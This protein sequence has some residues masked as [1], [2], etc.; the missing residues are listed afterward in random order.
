MKKFYFTFFAAAMSLAPL[1]AQSTSEALEFENNGIWYTILDENTCQTRAG[2]FI[3]KDESS[4]SFTVNYGNDASNI[5]DLNIPAKVKNEEKEYTVVKIGEFGF[6]NVTNITIPETVTSIGDYAFINSRALTS[7]TIPSSIT[8]IGNFIFYECESLSEVKLPENILSIGNEAFAYCKSLNH[9]D[10]HPSL[11]SIGNSAFF[12]AGLKNIDLPEGLTVIGD[13]AFEG[14]NSLENISFPTTLATIGPDAFAYCSQL[15]SVIFPPSLYQIGSR[16]FYHCTLKNIECQS[17]TPPAI[18]GDTFTNYDGI[19]KVYKT[20]YNAY[21][22]NSVWSKFTNLQYIPVEATSIILDKTVLDVYDGLSAYLTATMEP[23]DATDIIVWTSSDNAK[24]TVTQE[25]K[26][27][28]HALGTFTVTAS[29]NNYSATCEVTVNTNPSETVTITPLSNPVYIGDVITMKATV[30]PVSVTAPVEW[31]SSNPNIATI[32]SVTGELTAIAPGG[33]LIQASCNGVVGKYTVTVLP[34]EATSVKLSAE[35]VTLKVGE[36]SSITATVIPDNTT[37]PDVIWISNNDNVATVSNGVITATG[38]GSATITATCGTASAIVDV[39]VEE[40]PA[41]KVELSQTEITMK[42]NQR[43]QL[44]ATVYPENT[45]NKEVIWSSSDEAVAVVSSDGVVMTKGVGTATITAKCGNAEAI[46]KV[47][48]EATKATEV[49]LDVVS[50]MLQPS[51]IIKLTA[52]VGADVTDKTIKWSSKD[53]KVATVGD[54]GIVTAIAVGATTITATCGDV[55]A[56]CKVT[57]V[58]VM[59][60]TVV[61]DQG[62]ATVNTD[63]IIVLTAS[64]LPDNATDKTVV[65]TSDDENVATVDTEGKVRGE[66]P[67]VATI[68]ATSGGAFATCLVTVLSPAKSISLNVTSLSLKVGELTDIIATVTPDNTTDIVLWTTSDPTVASVDQNGI[69][70]AHSK[71]SALITVTCGSLSATC[72]IT[73]LEKTSSLEEISPDESGNYTVYSI[74]G[75]HILTTSDR[76]RINTLPSGIYIIKGNNRS[77][78]IRVR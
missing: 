4:S 30:K 58:P 69:V 63:E 51:Q 54:D 29:C 18:S 45:T 24:L 17:S 64:V 36:T 67:G 47:D 77:T 65:W 35:N 7:I 15:T 43:V 22:K 38:V 62:S 57:V 48:V 33:T 8:S 76:E 6:K 12:K 55:S 5:P 41:E 75:I 14:C 39:T 32:N 21:K 19:L 73:V 56:E 74:T 3:K 37:Y 31:S 9:I 27:T 46:C 13:R 68:T 60:E 50:V 40:T 42:A 71:G 66:A 78:K 11:L 49:I 25:G 1:K 23:V 72:S 28:G 61:L 26:I 53:V 34:I 59:V 44:T 20:S 70:E 16:A 2:S 52:T 10:L